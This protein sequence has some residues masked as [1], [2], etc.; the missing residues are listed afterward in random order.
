MTP[1]VSS[2]EHRFEHKER[3][4]RGDDADEDDR[5]GD[6]DIRQRRAVAG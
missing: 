2:K 5:Q 6:E 1:L 4:E 3:H